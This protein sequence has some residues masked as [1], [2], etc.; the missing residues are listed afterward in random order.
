MA[1]YGLSCDL[2]GKVCA[3]GWNAHI[4]PGSNWLELGNPG[5]NLLAPWIR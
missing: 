2:G 1:E 5:A 4:S 3:M